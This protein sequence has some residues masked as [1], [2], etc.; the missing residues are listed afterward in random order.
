M[1]RFLNNTVLNL[2]AACCAMFL[3][4]SASAEEHPYRIAVVTFLSG[5]ASGPFGVPARNAAE[6]LAAR[7]NDGA[8]PS[9]YAAKGIGGRPV[10]LHFIDEAGGT[11]KQVEQFRLLE[12]QHEYDAVVGYISSGDCLAIAPVAE[13]LKQLTVFSDCGTP[14]IFEDA[15][16]H[17]VFRTGSHSTMDAVGAAYYV[18]D[19]YPRI[20]SYAGINQNYAFGQDAWADFTAAMHAL[21][22]DATIATSQMPKPGAGQYGTEISALLAANADLVQSSFWGGDLEAFVLQAASRD[23][24]KKSPLLLISGEHIVAHLA[25][26]IPDGTI[27]GARGTHGLFAP[28]TALSRWFAAAYTERHKEAPT[29]VSYKMAQAFLGLKT[30]Y[31]KAAKAHADPDREAVIAAF[32]NETWE[33]PSG[34]VRMGL[35]KGHQALTGVAYGTVAHRDGKIVLNDV[36]YYPPEKVNPPEGVKSID[37]IAATLK[38][39][40]K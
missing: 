9:P 1:T 39:I 35:G 5:P 27:V 19:K 22:P 20:S 10:E 36:R 16:Y 37:W 40:A 12:Q 26:Q 31:E 15:A 23:L 18:L 29:Y 3:A 34:T 11:T 28:N 4:Q 6:L 7:L 32:E 33:T 14:R 25:D 24:A 21:K 2:T 30:A 8:L 17:Y 38:P 13:E